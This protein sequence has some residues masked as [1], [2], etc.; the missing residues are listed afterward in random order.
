M[1]HQYFLKFPQEI[2]GQPVLYT[3]GQEFSIVPNIRGASISQEQALLAVE[4]QGEDEEVEKAIAWL[5]EYGVEVETLR[6]DGDLP[7]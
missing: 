2:V 1:T 7:F 6:P 4:L 5:L 3:L